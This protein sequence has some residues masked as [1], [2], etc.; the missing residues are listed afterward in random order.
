MCLQLLVNNSRVIG[1]CRLILGELT[2]ISIL[3]HV[4]VPPHLIKRLAALSHDADLLKEIGEVVAKSLQVSLVAQFEMS[5]HHVLQGKLQSVVQS[6]DPIGGAAVIHCRGGAVEKQIAGRK[7]ALLREVDEGIARSVRLAGE[8]HL[9]RIGI[10]MDSDLLLKRDVGGSKLRAFHLRVLHQR[11]SAVARELRS[12]DN[13]IRTNCRVPPLM[14]GMVMGVDDEL[15]RQMR[16]LPDSTEQ[17]RSFICV[18]TGINYK[19]TSSPHKE[20]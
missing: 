8:V 17:L 5:G 2:K 14:V 16:D 1:K 3:S 15:H 12:D 13:R 19:D 6:L 18:E 4:D 11:Q 7:Y 20:G 10:E 9:H